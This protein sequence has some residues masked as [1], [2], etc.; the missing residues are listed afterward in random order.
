MRSAIVSIRRLARRSVTVGASTAARA[1]ATPLAVCT[2]SLTLILSTYCG[3]IALLPFAV[4]DLLS[5]PR[6]SLPP[7]HFET[8]STPMAAATGPSSLPHLSL[9]SHFMYP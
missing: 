8:A 1:A 5:W 9:S 6:C 2:S 4:R 7:F 3:P